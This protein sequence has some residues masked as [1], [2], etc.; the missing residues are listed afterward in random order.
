MHETHKKR[1]GRRYRLNKKR[2]FGSFQ[3]SLRIL[4]EKRS[5]TRKKGHT[6]TSFLSML[7]IG[8]HGN[9]VT[10]SFKTYLKVERKAVIVDKYGL[11]HST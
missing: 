2:H 8:Q 3:L 9:G 7:F 5:E 10:L 11:I 6:S 4:G 1:G